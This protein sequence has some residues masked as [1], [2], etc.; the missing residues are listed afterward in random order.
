[1]VIGGSMISHI[2]IHRKTVAQNIHIYRK[3]TRKKT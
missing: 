2:F 1:M 3:K